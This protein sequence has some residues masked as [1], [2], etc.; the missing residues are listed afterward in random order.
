M[1]MIETQRESFFTGISESY[2][3]HVKEG[4]GNEPPLSK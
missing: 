4:F 1:G 2:V 3:R